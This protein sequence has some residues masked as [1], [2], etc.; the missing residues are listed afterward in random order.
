[1]TKAESDNASRMRR[2]SEMVDSRVS[3]FLIARA[4]CRADD[5]GR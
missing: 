3:H 2:S 5:I 4:G 1:M